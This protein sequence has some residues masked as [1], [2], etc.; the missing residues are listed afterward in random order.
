M[1]YTVDL[2]RDVQKQIAT[3]PG[4]DGRRITAPIRALGTTP[5]PAGCKP[6]EGRLGWRLRVGNYRIVY[7]IDDKQQHVSIINVD[8]R[9]RVYR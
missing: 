3:F 8:Q 9:G 1:P 2:P 5:R 7:L 6:L 4:K